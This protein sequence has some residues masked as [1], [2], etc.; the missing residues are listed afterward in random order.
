MSNHHLEQ[1]QS[2]DMKLGLM[3]ILLGFRDTQVESI[4]D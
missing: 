4:V 2:G 3:H 1:A